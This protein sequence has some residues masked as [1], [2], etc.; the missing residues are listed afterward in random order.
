MAYVGSLD[1]A[2]RVSNR[3]PEKSAPTR[4]VLRRWYDAFVAAQQ[5]HAEREIARYLVGVGRLTDEV[6][7]EIERRLNAR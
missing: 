5:R 2:P 4:S 6:E 1:R 3:S 7:R